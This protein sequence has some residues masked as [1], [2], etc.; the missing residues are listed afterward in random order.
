LWLPP[1]LFRAAALSQPL[2]SQ[3]LFFLK[4]KKKSLWPDGP[5]EVYFPFF[6]FFFLLKD[7]LGGE[8]KE[9]K[10][11][12]KGGRETQPEWGRG[13]SSDCPWPCGGLEVLEYNLPQRREGKD[14][15]GD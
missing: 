15:G 5:S 14:K 4:K 3:F 6:F 10:K 8:R 9:E 13:D 12:K 2:Q 1:L 11:R 7:R